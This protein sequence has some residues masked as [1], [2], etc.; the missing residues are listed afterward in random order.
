MKCPKCGAENPEDLKFCGYCGS[1]I[2]AGSSLSK[3]SDRFRKISEDPKTG[4]MPIAQP[5]IYWAEFPREQGKV[6]LVMTPFRV[7]ALQAREAAGALETNPLVA[8]FG[9]RARLKDL[10]A[11]ETIYETRVM[12]EGPCPTQDEQQEYLEEIRGVLSSYTGSEVSIQGF[13]VT[14]STEMVDEQVNLSD[15]VT[16]IKLGRKA[17]SLEETKE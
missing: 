2:Q 14:S 15:S 10:S 11:S 5:G 9:T 3:R 17:K 1:S 12:Y 16:V 6:L 7:S 8:G 4:F 13:L